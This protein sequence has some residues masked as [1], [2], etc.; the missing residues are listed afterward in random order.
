MHKPHG[1]IKCRWHEFWWEGSASRWR[2]SILRGNLYVSTRLSVQ[3]NRI[4][5][6]DFNSRHQN[7]FARML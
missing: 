4:C 5:Q 3:W 2:C 7:V 1:M 6:G